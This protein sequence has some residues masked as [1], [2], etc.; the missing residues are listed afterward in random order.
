MKWSNYKSALSVFIGTLFLSFVIPGQEPG[1]KPKPMPEAPCAL[2]SINC[3]ANYP[4]KVTVGQAVQFLGT[5]FVPGDIYTTDTIV[6]NLRYVPAGTFTQGSPSTEACRQPYGTDETQFSH[7]LTKALAVMETEVTR[8]M[9]V[10]LKGAQPSLPD[11]PTNTAYG[12]GMTNPVQALTWYQ[13]VLFANLLSKQQGLR[14]VYYQDAGFTTPIN[15][16]PEKNTIGA[17]PS[18]YADWSANG[19]RLPTEGEWEYFARAGTTGPFSIDIPAYDSSTCTSCKAGT[20]AVLE[21]VAWYCAN[22]GQTTHPVGSKAANPWGL[23]DVHGN[24]GEWC[25]DLTGNYPSSGQT[26]F[27]GASAGSNRVYRDAGWQ[28]YPRNMR[29]GYRTDYHSEFYNVVLGFR[30]LRAVIPPGALYATDTIVGNLRYVQAGTF[31]QGTPVTEVGRVDWEGPQFQHTLTKNL[32]VM[33]TEVTRQMWA[34]LRATKTDLPADPSNT[35]LSTGLSDPVQNIYWQM[36]L[37]FANLLSDQQG[38]TQVYYKDASFTQLLNTSNYNSGSYYCN[39]DANGYRLPTEGEWE[40]FA[41]AGTTGPFSVNEP[42]YSSST[43]TSCTAGTLVALESVAWFC[44]NAGSTTHPVG[45][46]TANPWGF[47]DVH[48]NVGEW[49][50]DLYGSYP[51]LRQTDYRGPSVG[52]LRLARGGDRIS[53][54]GAARSGYRRNLL[55]NVA[56]NTGFRLVRPVN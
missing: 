46:K 10:D 51:T 22:S 41:R 55:P 14:Q 21:S 44:A 1:P 37:L 7:T 42:A 11:D 40:Y 6:G 50:W 27:R 34:D 13:A 36:T 35:V 33:E 28:G 52:G 8:Q 30:L 17:A 43:C 48:G 26:D 39:F 23:K 49:C 3:L 18:V 4:V 20:L 5:P 45:T 19:Y 53:S 29:S 54:S 16:A 31:T 25:W 32:A 2:G 47:K 56:Y 9:W 15:F 38:L 12:S 24:V